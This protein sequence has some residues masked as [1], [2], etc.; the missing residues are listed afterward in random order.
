MEEALQ[1][2][3]QKYKVFHNKR[4]LEIHQFFPHAIGDKVATIGHEDLQ[5]LKAENGEATRVLLAENPKKLFGELQ[6]HFLQVEAA[7]GLVL[8]PA[9]KLLV[10]KRNGIWDLPKGKVEI[11]ETVKEAAEREVKEECGITIQKVN[12]LDSI[13]YHIYFR[14]K[15]VLKPTYWFEML[16]EEQSL[17]PQKEEG[18]TQVLWVNKSDLK[19][20]M[21]KTYPS[22]LPIFSRYLG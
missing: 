9:N 17:T 13:T 1:N 4:V 3:P 20:I 12:R 15:W 14:K 7:G 21:E 10:I 19:S 22:L 6:S 16:A 18:I 11:G 8:S 5:F 2:E